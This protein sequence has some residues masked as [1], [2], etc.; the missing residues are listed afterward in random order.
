ML[1]TAG[2]FN[3]EVLALQ[4]MFLY[5]THDKYNVIWAIISDISIVI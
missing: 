4:L 1:K 2:L 3:F 5:K